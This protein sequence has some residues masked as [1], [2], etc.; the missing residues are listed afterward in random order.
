MHSLQ[1]MN[2]ILEWASTGPVLAMQSD[3]YLLPVLYILQE[4]DLL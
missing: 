4:N 1:T 3:W 2:A